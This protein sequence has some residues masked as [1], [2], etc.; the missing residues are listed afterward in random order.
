MDEGCLVAR[1]E[2]R[3]TV[4]GDLVRPRV[5]LVY[6][7]QRQA[8]PGDEEWLR[9]ELLGVERPCAHI[10]A[11]GHLGHSGSSRQVLSTAMVANCIKPCWRRTLME[12]WAGRHPWSGAVLVAAVAEVDH[13]QRQHLSVPFSCH[14]G[15]L[16]V[17][18]TDQACVSPGIENSLRCGHR[19]D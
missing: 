9:L 13:V 5:R 14:H 16:I 2:G 15:N 12:K 7:Q 6:L 1:A 3:K 19:R 10:H 18:L 17:D 8:L 11:Q 4:D